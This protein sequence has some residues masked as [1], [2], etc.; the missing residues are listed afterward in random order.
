[1]KR[2]YS[3]KLSAASL[4]CQ[5]GPIVF[6]RFS[7]MS[8]L[9]PATALLV[10]CL[11]W[12]YCCGLSWVRRVL[13]EEFAH[14]SVWRFSAAVMKGQASALS[15]SRDGSVISIIR[16]TPRGQKIRIHFE[17]EL[18][19]SSIVQLAWFEYPSAMGMVIPSVCDCT[20]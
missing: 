10:F 18:P 6:R 2:R 12:R 14:F 8:R 19:E 20:W 16:V 15:L 9:A 1:M 11:M 4:C 3:S 7:S 17:N 5:I 13:L